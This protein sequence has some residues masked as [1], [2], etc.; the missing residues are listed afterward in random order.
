MPGGLR[1]DHFRADVHSAARRGAGPAF[2]AHCQDRAAQQAQAVVH[3]HER[4]FRDRDPVGRHSCAGRQRDFRRAELKIL[5]SPLSGGRQRRAYM[6]LSEFDRW[7]ARFAAPGYL[8]GT[9]PNAFLQS[10]THL[11]RPGQSALA[12][13]DGEGRN[14]VFLAEQG[15]DVLSVDF[16]P[17]AQEKVRKLAAERSVTLR[18]EQA[19][20]TNWTWPE[21]AFDVVAAI[22][23][24]CTAPPQRAKMFA[25]IKRTLKP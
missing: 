10:Q 17:L 16:S 7:Q 3:G 9:A 22:F 23:I 24:Q 4:G 12:I 13:A 5:P 21:A 19:D 2:R 11:L 25:G 1:P 15:L 8:F 14:G 20:M 18:V 6:E